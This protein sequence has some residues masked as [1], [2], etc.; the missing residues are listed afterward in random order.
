MRRSDF[1]MS[2]PRNSDDPFD[3]ALCAMLDDSAAR[4][5]DG[6]FSAALLVQ[7]RR[8]ARVRLITLAAAGGIG[9]AVA[10][11]Q[12]GALVDL[13]AGKARALVAFVQTDAAAGAA[14][15][16][17]AGAGAPVLAAALAALGLLAV[18]GVMVLG[19]R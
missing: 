11:S 1:G 4:T 3:G 8:R 9:A 5:P 14:V 18:G 12:F 16:A 19:R 7:L 15:A 13:Y 10:A 2:E 17:N 6:G